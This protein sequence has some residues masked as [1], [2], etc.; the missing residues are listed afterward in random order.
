MSLRRV[1]K[2]NGQ[3]MPFDGERI[4]A[5]VVHAQNSVG[6]H[7]PAFAKEV[8]DLVELALR[9][10][11][12]WRG[13]AS[14]AGQIFEDAPEETTGVESVPGIEEIQD[15][16]EVG[17]VE[18]GHA[19][20]AK[21]YILYRDRRSRA[22]DSYEQAAVD[23]EREGSL[24]AVRVRESE[25]TFPWSKGR[26]VA[27]LI[28]EADLSRSQA[29]EVASRVEMRVVASGLKR[30]STALIREFV[31]NE[32]V[33]M[34]LSG[35]LARQAP[36]AIP[37]HDLRELLTSG[38]ESSVARRARAGLSSSLSAEAAL[39]GDLLRRFALD[40]VFEESLVERHLAGALHLGDLRAP[41]LYLTQALSCELLLRGEPSVTGAFDALAEAAQ[42]LGA[43]SRGLVLENPVSLLSPLVSGRQSVSE[44]AED[45]YRGLTSWLLAAGAMA[46]AAKRHV[47]LAGFGVK[48]TQLLGKLVNELD[49][50]REG[51]ADV[52]APRLILDRS[53]LQALLVADP[54]SRNLLER[55]LQAGSLI[56]T[57]S[58]EEERYLG[59]AGRRLTRER[60]ALSCGGA[61]ALNLA[62]LAHRAGPW[63]EDLVLEGLAHLVEE[64]VDA[65]ARLSEFQRSARPVRKGEARGRVAY[66]LVPV[67]LREALRQLGDGELRAEQG[68]RLLGLISDAARRYAKERGISVHI[69]TEYGTEAG[70]R[71]AL[72]DR[73]LQRVHQGLLFE[74]PKNGEDPA[75]THTRPYGV[76]YDLGN[77]P[78]QEPGR[79]QAQLLATVPAGAWLPLPLDRSG[80]SPAK[81]PQL[82][83]WELFEDERETIRQSVSSHRELPSHA[84]FFAL[85][86]ESPDSSDAI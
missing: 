44:R 45:R 52:F 21:A 5:A 50:L 58:P 19:A 75:I 59:P 73:A 72:C 22:R 1:R 35:T 16:V 32:L 14:S 42:F 83:A 64:A 25:G 27:A 39:G 31:D 13:E 61:V 84:P 48:G 80:A 11:Y 47:D 57:W 7:D 34:G 53:E 24:Q 49:A 43:V 33:S 60:G 68:S 9:R 67:G 4:A 54:T 17:L 74:R 30:I 6:Q 40:D 56:P 46:K 3:E 12:A 28:Q 23:E 41:H 18:L 55:L 76:G 70:V 2:R 29:Q 10:R 81:T 36:V 26:I 63:R 79:A 37:R 71:F 77:L 8:A 82:D 66:A 78:G 86:G 65:L 62:R 85:A 51:E 38:D 20:V 15:L 69:S